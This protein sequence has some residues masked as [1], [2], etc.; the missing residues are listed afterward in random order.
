MEIKNTIKTKIQR[1]E[2]P[3]RNQIWGIL[4]YLSAEFFTET[5]EIDQVKL[6]MNA[7]PK[8][9]VS[10]T[11]WVKNWGMTVWFI[12]H[13]TFYTLFLSSI[14][15]LRVRVLTCL[16]TPFVPPQRF[17]TVVPETVTVTPKHFRPPLPLIHPNQTDHLALKEGIVR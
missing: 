13:N 3:T 17:I 16:Q 9:H 8:R 4:K 11:T 2:G 10:V 5:S 6:C 15:N 1:E 7:R 14:T 12:L